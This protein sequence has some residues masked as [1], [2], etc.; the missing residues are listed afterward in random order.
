MEE[1]NYLMVVSP[2]TV[3]CQR[4]DNVTALLP[5]HQ[6]SENCA[7]ADHIPWDAPLQSLPLKRLC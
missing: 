1:M 2:Q 4:V 3:W 6:Q 5:Q 7:Q